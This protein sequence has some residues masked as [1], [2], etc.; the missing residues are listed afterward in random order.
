[1]VGGDFEVIVSTIV[2]KSFCNS[3]ARKKRLFSV[4]RDVVVL[5]LQGKVEERGRKVA[6]SK[7]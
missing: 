7:R 5:T 3:S 1:M 4:E 2:C 6:S